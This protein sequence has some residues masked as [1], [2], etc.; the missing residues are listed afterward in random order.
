MSQ[1]L[2]LIKSPYLW[3][4]AAALALR[5]YRLAANPLWLDEFVVHHVGRQG[6]DA[7]LT[8]SAVGPHPPL[9]YLLQWLLAGGGHFNTEW[10]WR[11][12]SV[13]SGSLTVPLLYYLASRV[14]SQRAALLSALLFMI[15]PSHLFFSQEARPYAFIVLLSALSILV[16]R[17][18][19]A[20]P[21]HRRS[22]IMLTLLSLIGLYSSYSYALIITAQ[23]LYLFLIHRPWRPLLLSGALLILAALPL[24]LTLRRPMGH[25][26]TKYAATESLSLIGS[27]HYLIVLD[28][29]RYGTYWAHRG[30]PLFV[31][32]LIATALWRIR[33][34]DKGLLLYCLIQLLLPLFVMFAL[35]PLWGIKL[36]P[37]DAKQ[38]MVLLPALFILIA[39]AL[40]TLQQREP[41]WLGRG[42]AAL[43][44]LL[45]GLSNLAGIQR[46]W[47][48]SKSPEGMAVRVVRENVLP[49]EGLIV[50]HYSLAAA[51]DFYLPQLPTYSIKPMAEETPHMLYSRVR[52][53][54]GLG[55]HT[56]TTPFLTLL[57]HHSHLW[58][59]QHKDHNIP[60]IYNQLA[61]LCQLEREWDHAP[62]QVWRFDCT[63]PP[64]YPLSAQRSNLKSVNAIGVPAS[65]YSR[66]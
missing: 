21:Y 42:A 35:L 11:W 61:T 3:L 6:I 39:V 58:L 62:F 60:M 40:D 45:L 28:P 30:A 63:A 20:D 31:A 9:Y 19:A 46:Y 8:H 18:L 49:G 29:L 54:N 41:P 27:I 2:Y 65:S 55:E 66:R 56:E 52:Y 59:L 24:L 38:L 48:I 50:L 51:T 53:G 22:W 37:K 10:T 12:P 33:A 15:A 47:T 14:A 26:I 36:P 34:T 32:F 5:L 16:V 7:L 43:L 17:Q 4:F 25:L 57:S 13:L 23:F 44:V 1:W 64:P